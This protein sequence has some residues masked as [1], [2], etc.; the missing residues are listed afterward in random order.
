MN[1]ASNPRKLIFGEIDYFNL[2]ASVLFQLPIEQTN[3]LFPHIFILRGCVM[4]KI[5]YPICCG[6][7]VHKSFLVAGIA[8]TNE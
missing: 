6:V 4:L 1:G 5:I 2:S 7:D 8:S 3:Y